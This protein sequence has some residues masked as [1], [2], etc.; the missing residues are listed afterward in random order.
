MPKFGGFPQPR[1]E[2][3]KHQRLRKNLKVGIKNL[4]LRKRLME[5][6]KGL[7]ELWKKVKWKGS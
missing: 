4:L 3:W 5:T 7:E 6:I 1:K 2:N